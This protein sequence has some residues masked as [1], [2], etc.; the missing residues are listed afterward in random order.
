[1]Q[2]FLFTTVLRIK[3][4]HFWTILKK[5]VYF[6]FSFQL[7]LDK[8]IEPSAHLDTDPNYSVSA[9]QAYYGWE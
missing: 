6:L 2:M 7:V 5:F 8:C 1:M 9:N 4:S 3:T